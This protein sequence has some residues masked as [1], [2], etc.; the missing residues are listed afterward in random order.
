MNKQIDKQENGQKGRRTE[1]QTETH[2]RVEQPHG[3][4]EGRQI[5]R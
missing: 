3:G 1:K 2:K 5:D 4:G